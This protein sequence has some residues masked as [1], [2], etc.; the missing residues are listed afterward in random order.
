MRRLGFE[1]RLTDKI[2]SSLFAGT[3]ETLATTQLLF[4]AVENAN[5]PALLGH[6]KYLDRSNTLARIVVDEC[7]VVLSWRKF[8][9]AMSNLLHLRQLQV[10][11]V[12]LTATLPPKMEYRLKL[13]FSSDFITIRS[14][15]ARRNLS[16]QV[17]AVRNIDEE[18][19]SEILQKDRICNDGRIIV[20][21][22]TIP[23]I[24][25][26]QEVLMVS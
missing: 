25:Q 13:A 17:K 21:C 10:P 26:L 12:L 23:E 19:V 24:V 16:Y 6:L 11:L 18:L 9:P 1:I 8:R 22:L 5:E 14:K 7:H 20:Y 3:G 2:D 15:T 4:V